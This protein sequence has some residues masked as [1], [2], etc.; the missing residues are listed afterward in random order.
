MQWRIEREEKV[1]SCRRDQP[2][3][4]VGGADIAQ[5]LGERNDQRVSWLPLFGHFFR[6]P[7]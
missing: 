7:S 3:L 6:A 4:A 2:V 5:N 1:Y